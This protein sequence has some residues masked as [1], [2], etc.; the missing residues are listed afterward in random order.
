MLLGTLPVWFLILPTVLAGAFMYLEKFYS[1]AGT[2]ATIFIFLVGTVQCGSL[3]VAGYYLEVR[4]W[5][6]MSQRDRPRDD[7]TVNPIASVREGD[8]A[9]R[10][11]DGPRREAAGARRGVQRCCH[12]GGGRRRGGRGE[13]EERGARASS[14]AAP[15]RS[16]DN[17]RDGRTRATR[18]DSTPTDSNAERRSTRRATRLVQ[19]AMDDDESKRIVAEMPI[20]EEVA[21]L[22]RISAQKAVLYDK[23]TDWHTA[24]SGLDKVERTWHIRISSL[25]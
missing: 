3:V 22:D 2:L 8:S 5:C 12:G 18:L 16:G 7:R 25:N 6:H 10:E 4:T 17:G 14:A 24:L 13:A 19:R 9:T 21:E 11:T 20:D 23:L 15:L 1:W